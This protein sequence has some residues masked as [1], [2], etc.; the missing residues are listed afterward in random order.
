VYGTDCST[1]HPLC[2]QIA[3][4]PAGQ[5]CGTGEVCDSAGQCSACQDG[6]SCVPTTAPCYKGTI[7]C[8]TGA[9]AASATAL[10]NGSSCGTDAVCDVGVCV[11][12]KANQ[13]CVPTAGACVEGRTDCSTGSQTCQAIGP[14]ADGTSCGSGN[15]CTGGSC[16]ACVSA[17]TCTPTNPC[18]TGQLGCGSASSTC[19]DTGNQPDNIYCGAE[20]LCTSGSCGSAG[21]WITR[22]EDNR[23]YSGG[24]VF[25][26]GTNGATALPVTSTTVAFVPSSGGR[27]GNALQVHGVEPVPQTTNTYPL[28]ALAW[29]FTSTTTAFNAYAM[30][31]GIDIWI[32]SAYAGTI[33]LFVEDVWT[34]PAFGYCSTDMS[35]PDLCYNFPEHDC[36]ITTPGVWTEFKIPWASFVRQDYGTNPLSRGA[37]VDATQ[38]VQMQINVP[39]TS[40][41]SAGPITYQFAVDD[42]SYLP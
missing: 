12:C 11:S 35:A 24:Y 38:A 39:A 8:S 16:G 17:G 37:E 32:N 31:S 19:T 28:G 27:T 34:T 2:V 15:V 22:G 30:G 29:T 3:N 7:T 42:V 23:T 20:E 1:G 9:C 18:H 36:H 40:Y 33:Q 21:S 10:A 5:A 6:A 41:S 4:A 13:P 26:F 14:V 25:T